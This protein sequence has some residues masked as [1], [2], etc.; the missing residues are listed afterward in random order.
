LLY[1]RICQKSDSQESIPCVGTAPGPSGPPR[2]PEPPRAP[3]A[4]DRPASRP[5]EH[6]STHLSGVKV[7]QIPP[8]TRSK[9]GPCLRARLGHTH[10]AHPTESSVGEL[11]F[12]R[13][14]TARTP[15]C[16]PFSGPESDAPSARHPGQPARRAAAVQQRTPPPETPHRPAHN[17]SRPTLVDSRRPTA[18]PRYQPNPRKQHEHHLALGPC[19][20][21]GKLGSRRCG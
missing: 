10:P 8:A 20:R 12:L 19:N 18:L 1:T 21:L 15:R 9:G 5:G 13:D 2:A 3:A 16:P 17:I 6:A 11:T 4:P 14:S 7:A